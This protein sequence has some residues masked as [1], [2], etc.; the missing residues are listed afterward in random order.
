MIASKTLDDCKPLHLRSRPE[1]RRTDRRAE[2]REAVNS[3]CRCNHAPPRCT[4]AL[5]YSEDPTPRD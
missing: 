3:L 2:L 1:T 4:S 5:T